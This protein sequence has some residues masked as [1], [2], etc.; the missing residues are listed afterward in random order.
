MIRSQSHLGSVAPRI[1]LSL[2]AAVHS[3]SAT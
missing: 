3:S 2:A 1:V